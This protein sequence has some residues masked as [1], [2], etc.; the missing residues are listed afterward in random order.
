MATQ[1]EAGGSPAGWGRP[2]SARLRPGDDDYP[3]CPSSCGTAGNWGRPGTVACGAGV[4]GPGRLTLKPFTI[5][6]VASAAATTWSTLVVTASDTRYLSGPAAAMMLRRDVF[7]VI[8][9]SR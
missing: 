6:S 9:F 5:A 2:P 1:Y 4:G 3:V 7:S 8:E